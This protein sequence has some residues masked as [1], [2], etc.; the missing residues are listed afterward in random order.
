MIKSIVFDWNGTLLADVEAGAEAD[1]QVLKAFGGKPV[2]VKE[3]RDT[4]D[5]PVSKFYAQHGCDEKYVMKHSKDM[6]AIFHEYYEKRASTVRSRRGAKRLL[7]WL[8]EKGIKSVI[9]SNHTVQGIETQL[10]RL[11]L[12]KYVNE[13]LAN[14]ELDS[15]LKE[16]TK[17]DKL[18][19]YINRN[20]FKKSEVLIVGDS[21]EEIEIGKRIG[22]KNVAITG[23]WVATSRLKNA[24]P[25]YLINNLGKLRS[26]IESA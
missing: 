1:N 21:T 8:K 26:I 17:L 4:F 12:K 6:A 3:F 9:L 5:F 25:D 23:G 10:Q 18:C 24:Q 20:N 14:T 2:S 13:V 16:R 15:T 19:D 22:I 11:E 7:Y